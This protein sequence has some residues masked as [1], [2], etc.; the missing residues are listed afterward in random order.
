MPLL[1]QAKGVSASELLIANLPLENCCCAVTVTGCGVS[2]VRHR[3]M[4]VGA[5]SHRLTRDPPSGRP[6]PSTE[7]AGAQAVA[8]EGGDQGVQSTPGSGCG[9]QL[10]LL[11]WKVQEIVQKAWAFPVEGWQMRSPRQEVAVGPLGSVE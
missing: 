5:L 7:A 10:P 6:A 8:E 3:A 9:C 2:A 1:Q 4:S 11:S